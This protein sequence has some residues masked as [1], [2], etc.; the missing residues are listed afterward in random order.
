MWQSIDDTKVNNGISEQ[1]NSPPFVLA[2]QQNSIRLM[3]PMIHAC[4]I[5]FRSAQR[6]PRLPAKT[7]R[8]KSPDWTFISKT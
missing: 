3:N 7:A 2:A 8:N 6:S 4:R 1:E 5:G